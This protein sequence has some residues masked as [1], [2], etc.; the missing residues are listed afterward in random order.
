MNKATFNS[1][2]AA[3]QTLILETDR[4]RLLD[5]DEDAL[6]GVLDRVRKQRAKA[7]SQYRRGAA[8]RVETKGARG[9]QRLG[10]PPRDASKAEL[11]EAALARVS[12]RLA[13]LA[14]ASA[15][16]LKAERLAAA[17]GE[18]RSGVPTPARARSTPSTS[19]GRARTRPPIEK[20]QAAATKAA[21]KRRQAA[22]DA[23][24]N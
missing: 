14:R 18:A 8:A 22:R 3:E 11:W 4:P 24:P 5:H 12:A 16:E 7:V 1:L 17:A 9:K 21:G 13:A 2:T 10:G 15:A 6:I 20:K 23:K 19:S